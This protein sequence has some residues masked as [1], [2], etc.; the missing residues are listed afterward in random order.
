MSL[1]HQTSVEDIN[2]VEQTISKSEKIMQLATVVNEEDIFKGLEVS[3]MESQLPIIC[4]D[5]DSALELFQ[6]AQDKFK[7]AY[8]FYQ[9][10]GWVTDHIEILQDESLLY[11]K[12]SE[13]CPSFEDKCKMHKRRIDMLEQVVSKLSQKHYLVK[14]RQMW[15]EIGKINSHLSI[16]NASL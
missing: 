16:T 12:L 11:K 4:K 5:Y 6:F 14:C 3:E 15:F 1:P 10:D 8:L 13:F 7:I 9:L 2:K